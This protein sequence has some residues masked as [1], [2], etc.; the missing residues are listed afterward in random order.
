MQ[1]FTVA[2]QIPEFCKSVDGRE[3]FTVNIVTIEG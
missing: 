2:D 3:K 1:E